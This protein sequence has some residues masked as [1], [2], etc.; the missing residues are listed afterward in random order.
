MNAVALLA[1]VVRTPGVE[2]MTGVNRGAPVTTTASLD[3]V[4]LRSDLC[5]GIVVYSRENMVKLA[6][7]KSLIFAP[8]PQGPVALDANR[9]AK[10]HTKIQPG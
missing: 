9:V 6:R 3:P 2:H 1:L 5:G 10:A 7:L 8:A 4:G